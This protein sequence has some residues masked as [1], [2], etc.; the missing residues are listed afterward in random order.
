MPPLK[1][2]S[3]EEL[4]QIHCADH[5]PT[6][7]HTPSHPKSHSSH[8]T[9]HP[10]THSIPPLPHTTT[11]LSCL[12]SHPTTPHPVPRYLS[13]GELDGLVLLPL[14]VVHQVH[15]GVV[16]PV[17][18]FLPAYQLLA[19]LSEVDV[20]VQGLLVDVAEPT[21]LLIAPVQLLPQLR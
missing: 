1:V 8:L 18:L 9:T 5:P 17:H 20:L 6:S 21:Q 19:L 11:S 13:E 16:S 7:P 2:P 14:Q 4:L 15:D 12:T 10:T 3:L